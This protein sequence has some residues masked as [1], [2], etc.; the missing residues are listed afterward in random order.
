MVE[1]FEFKRLLLSAVKSLSKTPRIFDQFLQ[2]GIWDFALTY[3]NCDLNSTRWSQD[4]MQVLQIQVLDYTALMISLYPHTF[5]DASLFHVEIIDFLKRDLVSTKNEAVTSDKLRRHMDL[6][7]SYLR[8]IYLLASCS[9][10]HKRALVDLGIIPVLIQMIPQAPR[11]H[12]I[13]VNIFMLISVFCWKSNINQQIFGECGGIAATIP[14]L[15]FNSSDH[16][17]LIQ[18]H[19]STVACIWSSIC[20]NLQNEIE[21][22]KSEGI[23]MVFDLLESPHSEVR[24]LSLGCILDL[25]ENPNCIFHLRQWRASSDVKKDIVCI[26]VQLWIDMFTK[27]SISDKK[28]DAKDSNCVIQ[29]TRI[30][31]LLSKLGFNGK[32][33]KLASAEHRIVLEEVIPF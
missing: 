5:D 9:A 3:I 17:E 29:C 28:F 11:L 33:T 21:L 13:T 10:G 6:I 1:E 26:L 27:E 18:T 16:Q 30:Y 8:V 12:R 32:E 22:F 20:G 19:V 24:S 14:Y 7:D 31:A 23:Y 2:N 4:Q 25:F 15:S